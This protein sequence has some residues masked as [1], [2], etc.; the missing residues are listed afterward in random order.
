MLPKV[1]Q[2]Y[3]ACLEINVILALKVYSLNALFTIQ[4]ASPNPI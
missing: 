3:I 2:S 1:C 4:L